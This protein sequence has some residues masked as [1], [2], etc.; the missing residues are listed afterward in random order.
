MKKSIQ[1]P[2]NI[3]PSK[4][5]YS[6]ELEIGS[7]KEPVKLLIDTGSSTLAFHA[8]NYSPSD[9]KCLELTQYAQC[10]TYG[11]GGWAGPVLKSKVIYSNNTDSFEIPE[12]SF[13][14]VSDQQENSFQGLDG[15]MGLAYHHLNNAYDLSSYYE[16]NNQGQ[17]TYPWGFSTEIDKSGIPVFKNFLRK[18][19]KK[20]ITPLFSA[21]EQKNISLNKFTLLTHRSVVHVPTANMT[22]NQK[23]EEVLNKGLF[24]IGEVESDS[25]I[26][27]G[28]CKNVKVLHDA[29]YNTNLLSVQVEGYDAIQAPSLDS[30]HL[31]S[32]FTN[33]IIDSGSSYLMLQKKIYQY[34]IDSLNKINPKLVTFIDA[35]NLAR[36]N[37][38][39][40]SPADLNL[41]DWPKL[42]FTFEGSE[43]KQ[44]TLCCQPDHYWQLDALSPNQVFFTL[45]SQIEKWPNQSIIGLPIISSYL[46]IFDRS[47]GSDGVI[48][49][50]DKKV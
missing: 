12:V 44:V 32:F 27:N 19:P 34:V 20:D 47:A 24:I 14:I 42:Y 11:K 30:G 5:C 28:K 40:Y 21:F 6:L 50:V 17:K 36:K 7:Q 4:G 38:T 15:V 10:V 26:F 29:Y 23:E 22:Q 37:N 3:A 41:Q 25:A 16:K 31:D 45:L 39:P 9:D 49:F 8:S 35:F 18:Y 48:K 46:C 13:S 33:S 43:E 1:F 2:I